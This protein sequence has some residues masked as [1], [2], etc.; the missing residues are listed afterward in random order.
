MYLSALLAKY[1]G[2]AESLMGAVFGLPILVRLFGAE[3][4]PVGHRIIAAC[5]DIVALWRGKPASPSLPTDP[6]P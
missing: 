4:T 6:K 3:N 5:S 2:L 1:P